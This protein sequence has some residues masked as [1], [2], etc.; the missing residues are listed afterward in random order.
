MAIPTSFSTD[1]SPDTLKKLK[2]AAG[3]GKAHEHASYMGESE[4][5]PPLQ[6]LKLRLWVAVLVAQSKLKPRSDFP[7]DQAYFE[8]LKGLLMPKYKAGGRYRGLMNCYLLW[9][10]KIGDR[11]SMLHLSNQ[12]CILT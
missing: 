5:C 8:Y 7:S 10:R 12:Y 1:I 11:S 4:P 6:Q 9:A 3:T 2:E